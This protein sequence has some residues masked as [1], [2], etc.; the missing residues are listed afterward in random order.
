MDLILTMA[1][2]YERFRLFGNKVPKYL[3]PLGRT[4]VLWHV[5][6]EILRSNSDLN[7]Y[8]LANDSDRDFQ[9]IVR[10]IMDD[11]SIPIQ[12]LAYI[13]DTASQLQTAASIFELFDGY[14]KI[15]ET[16]IAFTNIDTILKNRRGFF[17]RLKDIG[18]E[19]G[20]IDTFP[21]NS[22]EYSY[23]RAGENESV[24]DV[25]DHSRMSEKACSGLYGFGS[26][27]FFNKNYGNLLGE[28]SSGNFTDFY[29]ELIKKRYPIDFYFNS[30]LRDT[31]VLGT[32]EEYI[33]NI[34]RFK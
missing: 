5:I 28:K 33:V 2:K 21:G 17:D 32:P 8:L 14:F 15:S 10:S 3:M 25:A 22:H 12:N 34:H 7:L 18:P 20:L 4:T 24:E 27:Q 1:G 6:D 9:P 31:T 19:S 30:D 23:I 26:A 13:G 11:F 16:A 29:D